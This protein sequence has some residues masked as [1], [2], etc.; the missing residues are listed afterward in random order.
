MDWGYRVPWFNRTLHLGIVGPF[1]PPGLP[2]HV[3]TDDSDQHS[4]LYKL[5]I[6]GGIKSKIV[7]YYFI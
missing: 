2:Y 7:Y 3:H 1:S 4:F 6:P 5:E